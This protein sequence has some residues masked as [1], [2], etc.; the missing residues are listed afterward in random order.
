[1]PEVKNQNL[2]FEEVERI[3]EK[4]RK[5]GATA[6]AAKYE[7]MCSKNPRRGGLLGLCGGGFIEIK[8][9]GRTRLARQLKLASQQIDDFHFGARGNYGTKP[10]SIIFRHGRQEQAVDK[11]G[12]EA[13]L[14]VLKKE[15][16]VDGY[17]QTYY[18]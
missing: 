15:L 8:L 14:A 17:V 16:Q 13:A 1:M 5:K 2:T 12:L 10:V 11:A 18:N 3:V 9:D 7:Q 6:A 4:A